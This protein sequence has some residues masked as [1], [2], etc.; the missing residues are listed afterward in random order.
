MDG[1]DSLKL[2][3]SIVGG[4]SQIFGSNTRHNGGVKEGP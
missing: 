1:Q 4:D 3:L 2:L